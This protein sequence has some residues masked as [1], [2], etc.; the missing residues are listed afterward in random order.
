MAKTKE[1]LL[2]A[3]NKVWDEE[4][5]CCTLPCTDPECREEMDEEGGC[6]GADFADMINE[7][8]V[9]KKEIEKK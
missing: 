1:E 6:A 2:A 8:D 4:L 3:L 5:H 9:P 7:L